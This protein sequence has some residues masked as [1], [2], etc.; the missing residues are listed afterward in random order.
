MCVLCIYFLVMLHSLQ[1]FSSSMKAGTHVLSIGNTVL[2]PGS[3]GKSPNFRLFSK[4]GVVKVLVAQ[5]CLTLGTPWG[6]AVHG[7]L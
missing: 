6:V 2:I 1:D 7:I 4:C 3:P 5:S